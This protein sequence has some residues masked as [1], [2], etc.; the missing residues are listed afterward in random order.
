M[1][2]TKLLYETTHHELV[3]QLNL[4]KSRLRS[5]LSSSQPPMTKICRWVVTAA[6]AQRSRLR[7]G[8]SCGITGE[9]Q[10]GMVE[11]FQ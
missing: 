7:R 5:M 10:L 6:A 11:I 2:A 3:G 1:N 9:N 8:N 4:H